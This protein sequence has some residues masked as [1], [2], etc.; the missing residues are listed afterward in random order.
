LTQKGY[1]QTY[2]IKKSA[3]TGRLFCLTKNSSSVLTPP[4]MGDFEQIHA[5]INANQFASLLL[6]ASPQ[7]KTEIYYSDR[8]SSDPQ[9]RRL[10]FA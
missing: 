5:A 8:V 6:H 2:S 9:R 1:V 4:Q 3:P 7:C 10:S